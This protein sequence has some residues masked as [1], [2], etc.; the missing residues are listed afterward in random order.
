[1]V[2]YVISDLVEFKNSYA[3]MPVEAMEK[4]IVSIVYKHGILDN[5][6]KD[7]WC[8]FFPSE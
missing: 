7:N 4:Y 2:S 6:Y 8:V 5:S 3:E 1:M